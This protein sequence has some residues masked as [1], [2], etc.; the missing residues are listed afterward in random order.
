M[1]RAQRRR[2]ADVTSARPARTA[3]KSAAGVGYFL[4]RM[5]VEMG[6]KADSVFRTASELMGYVMSG[7]VP[8]AVTSP[9][10]EVMGTPP[11]ETAPSPSEAAVAP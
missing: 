2:A 3:P 1:P 5:A 10:V 9:A 6:C 11:P 4:L 8:S 7:A